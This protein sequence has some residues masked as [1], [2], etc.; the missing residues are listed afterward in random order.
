MQELPHAIP[1]DVVPLR[2]TVERVILGLAILVLDVGNSS[3]S[4]REWQGLVA[5]LGE[6]DFEWSVSDMKKGAGMTPGSSFVLL[7]YVATA[8]L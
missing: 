8:A 2:M 6:S 7:S 1:A 3:S 4:L 5:I